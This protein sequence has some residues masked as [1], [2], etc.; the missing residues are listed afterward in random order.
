M[1]RL[2]SLQ[3][4]EQRPILAH[5]LLG[6]TDRMTAG[7]FKYGSQVCR[8][9]NAPWTGIPVYDSDEPATSCGHS[10][11]WV[12]VSLYPAPPT[13]NMGL[14]QTRLPLANHHFPREFPWKNKR[15]KIGSNHPL[16]GATAHDCCWSHDCCKKYLQS[17]VLVMSFP[18]SDLSGSKMIKATRATDPSEFQRFQV[19]VHHLWQSTCIQHFSH[20]GKRQQGVARPF[21]RDQVTQALRS[22]L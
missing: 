19:D 8:Y 21:F 15:R 16:S 7:V 20:G 1:S 17:P 5:T 6:G 22:E 3:I 11:W 10:S 13:P 9:H 18:L 4:F 2:G 12:Q 14:F